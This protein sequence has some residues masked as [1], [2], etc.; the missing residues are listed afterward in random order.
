MPASLPVQSVAEL[1]AYAA[2]NL[3]ALN[4]GTLGEGSLPEWF[5]GWFA[6]HM[7]FDALRVPI[8]APF[9]DMA[10]ENHA[11]TSGASP[12]CRCAQGLADIDFVIRHV[13]QSGLN[14]DQPELR[15]ALNVVID[16]AVVARQLCRQLADAP[17]F[18]YRHIFEQRHAFF[19][20]RR[21]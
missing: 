1:R 19:G 5:V 6:T 4:L 16:I 3:A 18:V 7:T 14:F 20:Q 12:S 21:M 8:H 10:F 15:Q 13:Q 17:H 9:S 11:S 2:K